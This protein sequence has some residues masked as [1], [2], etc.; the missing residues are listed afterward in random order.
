MNKIHEILKDN[1]KKIYEILKN[2]SK[3]LKNTCI[4]I[5]VVAG[6]GVARLGACYYSYVKSN[7]N[8]T[9]KQAEEIAL[10]LINGGILRTE[11]EFD[12]GILEYKFE[13]MDDN[14]IVHEVTINSKTG[15]ITDID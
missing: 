11:K 4:V 9:Q 1:S 12:D 8:Y 14:N 15:G 5:S 6:T 2:N 10:S 3:K 7:I 13:I